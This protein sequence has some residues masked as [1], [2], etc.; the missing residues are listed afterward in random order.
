MRNWHEYWNHAPQVFERDPLRQV[1]KTVGGQPIDRDQLPVVVDSIVEQLNIG[2]GDTVLDLC[3]GNGILTYA[4]ARH[5]ARIRGVDFS[6]PLI[7][8]AQRSYSGETITYSC[9]DVCDLDRELVPEC[10][11]KICLYE[12]LQHLDVE[13]ARSLLSRIAIAF[14]PVP[15]L[16]LGAVPDLACLEAFYDTP[17]RMAEF[18]R[19]TAEGNEAIGTWWTR[20]EL[21][22]LAS[23]FGLDCTF[24]E[25]GCPYSAHY[26]FD[27]LLAP[28][29]AAR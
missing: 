3:C 19:R 21:T 13:R 25:T 18:R 15:P 8:T 5:C 11:T 6:Q 29:M 1:G 24:R 26:R 2:A 22:L 10:V 9:A 28:R 7:E 17:E 14:R 4:L 23:S 27:A 20:D 16:L 12:G